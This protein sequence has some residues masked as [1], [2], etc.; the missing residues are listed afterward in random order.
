MKGQNISVN[1]SKSKI[2]FFATKNV[3]K[4]NE[5]R[6]LLSEY[7]ITTAMLRVLSIE[8]QD[9]NIEKIAKKRVIN[10]FEITDLPVIIEDAGLFIKPLNGFPGPYSS[11]VFRT[12][13]TKGILKLMKQNKDRDAFFHSILAFCGYKKDPK[14][15]HG[16]VKGRIT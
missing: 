15:F 1:F 3:H 9:D 5:T 8:V 12:L 11:Y 2:V 14:F 7:K 6:Q 13:G 10:A 16:K 4:F